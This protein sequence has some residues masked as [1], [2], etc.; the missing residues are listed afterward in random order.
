M[1]PLRVNGIA[2]QNSSCVY[3]VKGEVA[4]TYELAP[5]EV[6]M[7]LVKKN[8]AKTAYV[9][10]EI[11]D[12]TGM[13]V[14]IIYKDGTYNK[15]QE[16]SLFALLDVIYENGDSFKAGDTMVVLAYTY[17]NEVTGESSTKSVAVTVT[18]TA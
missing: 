12:P 6:E 7:L 18:V 5:Q 9:E 13:V 16:P 11:F 8:P 1:T 4:V 14:W 15:W 2:T 3:V 10:G 17:V